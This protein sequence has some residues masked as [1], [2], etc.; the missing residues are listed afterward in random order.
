MD[1]SMND[2]I[3]ALS[4]AVG[5]AGIAIVRISG[6]N[7]FPAAD[8]LFLSGGRTRPKKHSG[9]PDGGS[10]PFGR[11]YGDRAGQAPDGHVGKMKSH[12][13]AYG[14]VA[15]PA[16]GGLIDEVLLLKMASPR[17]YTRE[18]VVEIHC[19]GGRVVAGEVLRA[20]FA[21]GVRPA[22]AGEFTRRAFL[23]GR[24]DLAEAE[25]VMD[26]VRSH[27]ARGARAAMEQLDGRLSEL[28]AAM[29][30]ALL[31]LIGQM[32]ANLD[33]P[34]HDTGEVALDMAGPILAELQAELRRL[35]DSYSQG[36]I[37]RE[38]L[39]LVI[40]GRP[41]AGK[42]SLMN[43][44][45][46]YDRSIVD[47]IPGTTRDT[48]E[49]F[50]NLRGF[51]VHL[52][53]TA[54]LREATDA[55][56]KMGVERTLDALERAELVVAVFD[57]AGM[58]GPED[59]KLVERLK[60]SGIRSLYVMN[61]ADVMDPTVETALRELLPD[62]PLAVSAL[63]GT[64]IGALM[65]RIAETASGNRFESDNALL[66]TNAR[67]RHLLEMAESALAEAVKACRE[68]MTHDVVAFLLRDAWS[69]LGG[70]LGADAGEELL[71]SIF[72]RFC[73]GK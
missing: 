49:S 25:A 27:T 72:S 57:G 16:D 31:T 64:G 51:P 60:K 30:E 58:P 28:V 43:R 41:N 68:G 6:P 21:Q 62:R 40:A 59:A 2:T 23:N 36:R 33:F 37:L 39:N 26:L 50:I 32:E 8:R 7:A 10:G 66:L 4:T 20:V 13:V 55:V 3:A 1:Y 53:D 71:D 52:L 67:H 73:I 63:L 24:I 14:Q 38:G 61:K 5:D 65:D 69:L 44:L 46:G 48:V 35:L 17:T 15:D 12:T 56:E 45:A 19:H 9:L 47:E 29:R 42:S 54:G 22:E 34:E 11:P 18:D 70:I